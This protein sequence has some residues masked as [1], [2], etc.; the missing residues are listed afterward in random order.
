MPRSDNVSCCYTHFYKKKHMQ[1]QNLNVKYFWLNCL[2]FQHCMQHFILIKPIQSHSVI[3]CSIRF[4]SMTLRFEFDLI[5]KLS[6]VAGLVNLFFLIDVFHY[7]F[8]SI[9]FASIGVIDC[10]WKQSFLTVFCFRSFEWFCTFRKML[11]I[12]WIENSVP[13]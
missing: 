12:R 2:Q 10:F 11:Q 4:V 6:C 7:L 13:I 3:N 5:I 9:Y 8:N 1:I